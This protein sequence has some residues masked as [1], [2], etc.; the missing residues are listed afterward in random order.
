MKTRFYLFLLLL[1]FNACITT[2][3]EKNTTISTSISTSPKKII[4]PLFQTLLDSTALTGVIVIF[5]PQKNEYYANNFELAEQGRL[6]ASTFKIPNS[7]I[8]LETGVVANDSIV[9]KWDGTD[10]YL[11]IWE[12][13][14]TFK[15]AFRFS[16]VPCYQEIAQKIDVDHMNTFLDK[17][18]YGEITVD[19]N[20]LTNFWLQG[21]ARISPLE[22]I[23]FLTRLYYNQLPISQRTKQIVQQVMLIE[24]N[25]IGVKLSGKTG[26]S[27]QGEQN[28]G[29]F[30]GYLEQP[31]GAVYFFATNITPTS[32]FNLAHF[33]WIRKTIT[34]EALIQKGIWTDV[35]TNFEA[36][37]ERVR[38]PI[39]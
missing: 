9:F 28:N 10:R 38:S 37:K 15:E 36:V 21:N 14:L 7:I 11:A 6:P 2:P 18:D 31:N 5:D 22:Q 17:L 39:L 34:M 16:C 27:I 32:N 20:N 24:Q 29:W 33:T 30:V 3:S 13:D 1:F 35:Y 25:K 26:W 12:Q 8:A 4:T 19:S 23:D